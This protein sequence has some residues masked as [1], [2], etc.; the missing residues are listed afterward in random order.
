MSVETRSYIED[1]LHHFRSVCF[2]RRCGEENKIMRIQLENRES[3]NY[4]KDL[5]EN[6]ALLRINSTVNPLHASYLWLPLATLHGL[7]FITALKKLQ[8]CFC[9][10]KELKSHSSFP[11]RTS[12]SLKLRRVGLFG[13][14]RRFQ[15][16]WEI[17]C[18]GQVAIKQGRFPRGAG[19]NTHALARGRHHQVEPSSQKLKCLCTP[20]SVSGYLAGQAMFGLGKQCHVY[21]QGRPVAE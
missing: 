11:G 3:R 6:T 16:R 4:K 18:Q 12:S 10:T 17:P 15:S 20:D 9:R 13:D 21:H 8:S 5:S 19:K 2:R 14:G 1:V 7:L